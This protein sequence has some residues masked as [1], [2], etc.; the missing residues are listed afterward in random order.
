MRTANIYT[1]TQP[2]ILLKIQQ[3]ISGYPPKHSPSCSVIFLHRPMAL[4]IHACIWIQVSTILKETFTGYSFHCLQFTHTK[5]DSE[6]I[7]HLLSL[8]ARLFRNDG[9]YVCRVEN[10]DVKAVLKLH[11]MP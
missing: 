5:R 6:N 8:H 10:L 7:S 11:I 2:R 1:L 3:Y 4:V 9:D